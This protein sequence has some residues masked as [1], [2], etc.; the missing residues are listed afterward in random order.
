MTPNVFAAQGFREGAVYG[1]VWWAGQ[2]CEAALARARAAGHASRARAASGAPAAGSAG[3]GAPP[4]CSASS[5]QGRAAPLLDDKETEV[6]GGA[7]GRDA[8]DVAMEEGSV[9]AGVIRDG[10]VAIVTAA[11]RNYFGCLQNL[12]GSI[13]VWG[14][15]RD[16]PGRVQVGAE[17]GSRLMGEWEGRRVGGSGMGEDGRDGSGCSL[18]SM[19]AHV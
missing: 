2:V 5:R 1:G 11:S 18:W 6:R 19:V 13:H 4:T 8:E 14:G 3:S 12:V 7:V 9:G 17:S 10:G 16:G 15:R